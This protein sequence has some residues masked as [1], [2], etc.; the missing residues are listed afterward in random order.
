MDLFVCL[1]ACL[2]VYPIFSGCLCLLL[3]I[4][5]KDVF[6]ETHRST[7]I[8]AENVGSVIPRFRIWVK[9]PIQ[10]EKN[11]SLK[12]MLITF[13]EKCQWKEMGIQYTPLKV[14]SKF[15]LKNE[16]LEDD[17]FFLGDLSVAFTVKL[18]W[19][20]FGEP[21]KKNKPVTMVF[22]FEIRFI[23]FI[24]ASFW[25]SEYIFPMIYY[26]PTFFLLGKFSP[27]KKSHHPKTVDK[28]AKLHLPETCRSAQVEFAVPGGGIFVFE[29]GRSQGSEKG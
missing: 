28:P 25:Y 7:S 15:S 29:A 18:R 1:F 26:H 13:F 12:V 2:F 10:G 14:N 21:A 20:F 22:Q 6:G 17:P 9:A 16:W 19:E 11:F 3:W 24:W 5:I 23:W 8:D 4:H 27:P